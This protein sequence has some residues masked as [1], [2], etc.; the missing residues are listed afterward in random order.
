MSGGRIQ[1]FPWSTW[2]KEFGIAQSLGFDE[3]EFVFDYE[4]T[5]RHLENPILTDDGIKLISGLIEKT[6]VG[7]RSVCADYFMERPFFRVSRRAQNANVQTLKRLIRQCSKLSVRL[8]EIP[9]VDNSR[10]E[11]IDE[12]QELIRCLNECFETIE[13]YDIKIGLETDLP[14]GDFESLLTDINHPLVVASYDTGNSAS[15]G[16]DP[17]EE[18]NTLGPWIENVHIKDRLFK[19]GTVLL[20]AGDTDF[21][22]VFQMLKKI[23]YQKSLILQAARCDDDVAAAASYRDFTLE[24]WQEREDDR[25]ED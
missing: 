12:K 19:G 2:Q 21:K 17:E 6:T 13:R 1:S 3:I 11:T 24:L 5:G 25:G 22:K 14:P 9:L 8:I 16:F 4:D 7:V 10:I 15:L 18:I 20:G 23:D